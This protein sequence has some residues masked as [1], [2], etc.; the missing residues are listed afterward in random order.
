MARHC[1]RSLKTRCSSN[2]ASGRSSAAVEA[3]ACCCEGVGSGDISADRASD[4]ALEGVRCWWRERRSEARMSRT[5][6]SWWVASAS[7]TSIFI[8]EE[9]AFK[10]EA[11]KEEALEEEQ[12]K[13]EEAC[14]NTQS[15]HAERES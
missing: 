6:W 14:A 2:D 13:R 3:A 10:E 1:S 15:A 5:E 12:I 9:E 11:S 4:G 7:G 8:E